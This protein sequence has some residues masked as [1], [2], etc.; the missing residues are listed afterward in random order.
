[1]EDPLSPLHD[2][3]HRYLLESDSSDEEGQGVYGAS[4]SGPSTSKPKIQTS[5]PYTV[6]DIEISGDSWDTYE[7]VILGVGQAGR[8]LHRKLL[9]ARVNSTFVVKSRG[10]ALGSGFELGGR[11]LLCIDE[12]QQDN[13]HIIAQALL[14][15]AG[16]IPWSV[17]L[18]TIDTEGYLL[19]DSQAC[20][21]DLPTVSLHPGS[22]FH[23]TYGSYPIPHHRWRQDHRQ[24]S[25]WSRTDHFTKLRDWAGRGPSLKGS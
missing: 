9:G 16:S 13:L 4:G 14:E 11:L 1:M 17:G 12:G 20:G 18:L 22:T 10:E 23:V 8:Y 19:T 7:E 25:G 3:P 5:A 21:L 6:E 24:E 2:R 15:K